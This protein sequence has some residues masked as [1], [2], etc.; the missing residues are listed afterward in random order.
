MSSKYSTVDFFDPILG[1]AA[2]VENA[3]ANTI[4]KVRN[5]KIKKNLNSLQLANETAQAK[6]AAMPKKLAAITL[7]TTAV[8]APTVSYLDSKYNTPNQ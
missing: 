2:L 7:G 5:S 6:K 3:L 4:L 8:A 1:T